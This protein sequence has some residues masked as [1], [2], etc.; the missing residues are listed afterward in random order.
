MEETGKWQTCVVDNAYEIY[1][2]YPYPIRR[3]GSEVL[4][5]ESLSDGY[6]VCSLNRQQY[7]KHRIIAQQ[8]IP[9]D[10]PEHKSYIDHIDRNKLNNHVSNLRWV[11]SSENQLNKSSNLGIEYEYV[12][13]IDDEAI[14]ITDYGTH[15]F[16]SYYYV[17]SEDSF[18]FFNGVKYRRLHININK[19]GYTSIYAIDSEHNKVQISILTFKRLYGITA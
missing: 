7:K 4:I 19:R 2:Q 9:N 8:W 17:E 13:D 16:K 12:D 6:L 5:K 11:S 10:D 3:K 18:Y 15:H 1:D 14:E